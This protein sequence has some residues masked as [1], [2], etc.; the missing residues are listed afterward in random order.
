VARPFVAVAS[1][2]L[3]GLAAGLI[4]TTI[5]PSTGVYLGAVVVTGVAV[6]TV[7]VQ[8]GGRDGTLR[9]RT[10]AALLVTVCLMAVAAPRPWAAGPA[11]DGGPSRFETTDGVVFA[12]HRLGA[13][14]DRAAAPVIFLHGGPGVSTR[15][16]DLLWLEG[17]A[18]D[19]PVL[20]YDQIGTG[21]SSRLDDPTGYSLERAR[22]DL[23][24]V[25]RHVGFDRVI[26]VG[27]SWGAVVAA[28]YVAVHPERVDAV[29]ALTPGSLDQDTDLADD[30]SVRLD[31]PDRL[32]L[33]TRLLRPRELYTYAL[34]GIDPVSAHHLIGDAEMDRRYDAILQAVWPAMFCD[35]DRAS[36]FPPPSGGFYANQLTQQ[37][38]SPEELV[39]EIADPP[40][41]LVVKPECD[42]LPWSTVD[43]YVARLDAQVAYVRGGGH[44]VHLEQR[45]RV[46]ELVTDFLAGRTSAEVLADP[47][48][49]PPT[50]QGPP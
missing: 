29:I 2:A 24:T 36:Q 39:P 41:T 23:E 49:A 45:D 8:P 47:T 6:T 42:Y 4:A 25:R 50:F 19:R 32:R 20:A 30:P 11:H 14:R 18:R 37:R 10:T 46:T 28:S 43:G 27:H 38:P 31:G 35:P 22:D 5:R 34:S 15:Q 48:T 40:P 21:G 9:R 26:L 16:Q 3:A 13:G 12:Y 44:S 7:M 1:G 33:L 17:L